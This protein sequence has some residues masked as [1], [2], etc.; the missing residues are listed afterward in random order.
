MTNLVKSGDYTFAPSHSV[1]MYTAMN[2]ANPDALKE[3]MNEE[4]LAEVEAFMEEM[5]Q[6]IKPFMEEDPHPP[7]SVRIERSKKL[8]EYV[9]ALRAEKG[10]DANLLELFDMSIGAFSLL[11]TEQKSRDGGYTG[12]K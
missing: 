11:P 12:P 8:G 1:M 4:K 3:P 6:Q 7:L 9:A 2:A 5:T 10:P